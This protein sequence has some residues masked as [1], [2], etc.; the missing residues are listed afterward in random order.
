VN[1]R[2]LLR[3]AVATATAAAAAATTAAATTAPT[4]ANQ[5]SL[6]DQVPAI[7]AVP[8]D[9]QNVVYELISN[10]TS[11]KV[12]DV[13]ARIA[14]DMLGLTEEQVYAMEEG[15]ASYNHYWDIVAHEAARILLMAA[16]AYYTLRNF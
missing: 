12:D 3:R 9:V 16:N 1:R 5:A 8:E 4:P 7:N 6:A 13:A 15:S 11:D 2:E 14:R 10:T